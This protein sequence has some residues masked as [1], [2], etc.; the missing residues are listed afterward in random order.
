MV[1]WLIAFVVLWVALGL[2][3][4]SQKWSAV[5]AWGGSLVVAL[6]IVGV[7]GKVASSYSAY[8][9]A[10][11]AGQ[12]PGTI[13]KERLLA[14][15]GQFAPRLEAAPAADGRARELGK[16]QGGSIGALEVSGSSLESD[17]E[18]ATLIFSAGLK[19]EKINA[20]NRQMAIRYV[21][22]LFP[23]WVSPDIWLESNALTTQE[24]KTV[25]REGR[26]ITVTL[27]NE[28]SSWLLTVEKI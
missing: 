2:W 26:R 12:A 7:G 24:T 27:S 4:K 19:D 9:Q 17:V 15:L 18:K 13:G 8:Q 14:G 20:L 6:F 1:T 28:L 3:A 16:T 11:V 5:I 10:E 25:E 22:T 23:E 21:Q